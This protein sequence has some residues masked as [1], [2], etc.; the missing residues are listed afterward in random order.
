ICEKIIASNTIS[1]V[2]LFPLRVLINIVP[3]KLGAINHYIGIRDSLQLLE[4]TNRNNFA[5][6]K[7]ETKELSIEKDTA[8]KQKWVFVVTATGSLLIL[9]LVYIIQMQRYKT[10]QLQLNENQRLANEEIYKLM[11]DQQRKIEEG[12]AIEKK[13]IARE[14][15]DGIMNKL[16]STRLN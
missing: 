12:R 8:I 9:L 5:R 2:K 7:Y 14:L 10:R 6:I 1:S 11:I 4:R 16:T 15:H 13:R 3:D